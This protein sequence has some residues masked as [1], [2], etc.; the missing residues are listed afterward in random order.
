[1]GRVKQWKVSVV[2]KT[3]SGPHPVAVTTTAG[4]V[5]ELVHDVENVTSEMLTQVLMGRLVNFDWMLV[6]TGDKWITVHTADVL[7]IGVEL[8]PEVPVQ[9]DKTDRVTVNY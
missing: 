2:F 4:D 8:L 5:L 3:P 1:M 9:R 7:F 6:G